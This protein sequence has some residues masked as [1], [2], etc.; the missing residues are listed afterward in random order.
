MKAIV[1]PLNALL[2]PTLLNLKDALVVDLYVYM[3]SPPYPPDAHL[4]GWRGRFS[5][6]PNIT[7]KILAF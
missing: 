5:T 6:S 4:W 1:S 3:S 2:L 7:Q